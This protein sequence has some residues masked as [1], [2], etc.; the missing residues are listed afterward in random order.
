M[1]V[2]LGNQ[3]HNTLVVFAT[4]TFTVGGTLYLVYHICVSNQNRDLVAL[5]K[6]HERA[7]SKFDRH[8]SGNHFREKR[9]IEK[10]KHELL[11]DKLKAM[12]SLGGSDEKEVGNG[13]SMRKRNR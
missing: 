10:T 5:I 13:V 8:Y 12:F 1:Q 4:L 9:G 6:S 3:N 2:P 11:R 7:K